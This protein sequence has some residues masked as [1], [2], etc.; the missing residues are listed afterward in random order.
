[1]AIRVDT[2]HDLIQSSPPA[3][4]RNLTTTTSSIGI[5]TIHGGCDEDDNNA[6]IHTDHSGGSIDNNDSDDVHHGVIC[7]A[8]GG[9]RS[10]GG[11]STTDRESSAVQQ[12]QPPKE[13]IKHQDDCNNDHDHHNDV[14]EIKGG[15]RYTIAAL[16]FGQPFQCSLEFDPQHTKPTQL[17]SSVSTLAPALVARDPARP[18]RP[19]LIKI[20]SQELLP[21]RPPPSD[22]PCLTPSCY[23]SS[24]S[25]QSS[26]SRISSCSSYDKNKADRTNI[27]STE[28]HTQPSTIAS[29]GKANTM[30]Y[31]TSENSPKQQLQLQA[32]KPILKRTRLMPTNRHQIHPHLGPILQYQHHG[33]QEQQQQQQQQDR[34]LQQSE[35]GRSRLSAKTSQLQLKILSPPAATVATSPVSPTSAFL[36]S[37]SLEAKLLKLGFTRP[38]PKPPVDKHVRWEAY[39]EV[40]EI[41]NIDE[42]KEMGYYKAFDNANGWNYR[43][44]NQEETTSEEETES[45][46]DS[47]E[48]KDWED[49]D[50][51]RV[52]QLAGYYDPT[53]NQQQ[54][55]QHQLYQQQQR[56][57]LSQSPQHWR[58]TAADMYYPES[59]ASTI[60]DESEMAED[61]LLQRMGNLH[62]L[63]SPVPMSMSSASPGLQ[64]FS[65]PSQ[66]SR[67]QQSQSIDSPLPM[68]TSTA[69]ATCYRM[70]YP[71][72]YA[73]FKY[74]PPEPSA[75]LSPSIQSP[76]LTSPLSPT[77]SISSRLNE[78]PLPALPIEEDPDAPELPPRVNSPQS[79]PSRLK[80]PP[81]PFL[82]R[83]SGFLPPSLLQQRRDSLHH[84]S[85]TS[86]LMSSAS[87]FKRWAPSSY[88]T[89]EPVVVGG[90]SDVVNRDSGGV[91]NAGIQE[92]PSVQRTMAPRLD[93]GE[94]WA[95]VAERKRNEAGVFARRFSLRSSFNLSPITSS[96]RS[97]NG[98]APEIGSRPHSPA[99]EYLRR[100]GS[101]HRVDTTSSASSMG[102]TLVPSIGNSSVSSSSQPSPCTPVGPYS[103]GS[104]GWGSSDEAG[105]VMEIQH[106]IRAGNTSPK[107]AIQL[108]YP[109]GASPTVAY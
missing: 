28:P 77:L 34:I 74:P 7:V 70:S 38:L 3:L 44:G 57:I 97:S 65:R 69:S 93:R 109:R 17:S 56:H 95:E 92:H 15:Y 58:E 73:S 76:G 94:I 105:E 40:I 13:Y 30:S 88:L 55:K 78:R 9:L 29:S 64:L 19:L 26:C 67:H 16:S 75:M 107:T 100:Y 59:E 10:G 33:Q 62:F 96:N 86:V 79:L 54:S 104:A 41:E 39:N 91:V 48:E 68:N 12:Q 60:D 102:S 63:G 82:S 85:I 23:S 35:H 84:E 20:E 98:G 11:S 52:R 83:L 99:T 31:S 49:V 47:E 87:D 18:S 24:L 80:S 50:L 25:S 90:R 27:S 21:S 51:G 5:S 37:M 8:T 81:P 2:L 4:A 1:M 45:E 103:I 53:Q 71:R 32:L 22:S 42:L 36:S 61:D 108:T 89:A 66:N 14:G 43:D 72:T 6:Y 46:E 106:P 101:L